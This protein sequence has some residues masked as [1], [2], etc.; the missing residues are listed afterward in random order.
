MPIEQDISMVRLNIEAVL[1][2]T[3]YF[4]PPMVQR[5]SGRI[6]NVGSVAG[7][8]PGPILNVYHAAKTFVD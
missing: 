7:F 8:N 3:K 4:L 5:R 2:L 6:L 1:R